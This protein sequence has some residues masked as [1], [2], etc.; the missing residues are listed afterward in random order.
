MN[1]YQAPMEGVVDFVMREMLARVGGIDRFVTEFVRV[2]DQLLPDSTFLKY[3]PELHTGGKASNGTP[4]FVQLLGGKPEWL[5]L[6]AVAAVQLGAPGIDLNF[7][8][9]AKTVNRHDGGAALLK[10]PS[11]V[12][13]CVRAV[14][15][16]VPAEIPVTAKVR[17]GFEHKDFHLDIAGH[18]A[19]AG[20]AH[21]TVHARTKLE[22]YIPPAH[23]DYIRR[24]R[25]HV[26]IPVVANGEIWT[27][28]DFEKCRSVTG[29]S[30][31]ALGRGLVSR[32]SLPLEIRGEAPLLPW[33]KMREI[34]IEFGKM[35]ALVRHESFAV[36]R[37][38]QW[39]KLVCRTYPE[40]TALF[41]KI[42]IMSTLVP[43]LFA[44]EENHEH[45]EHSERDS[46]YLEQLPLLHPCQKPA[47][48]ERHPV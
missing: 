38:K 36:S 27:V 41:D 42:K 29:C 23:W 22:G 16:A 45:T 35:S 17:L 40:G 21:L 6:N 39:T 19:A 46:L 12:Y 43:M 24:M 33:E 8:C 28:E 1:L 44:L 13:D 48:A 25:E 3:C 32:P 15:E 31:F 9:P 18:A 47:Q 2:T 7:G 11:R 5:A 14:R 26:D 20:A 37:L 4:V 30:A 10:I 34:L